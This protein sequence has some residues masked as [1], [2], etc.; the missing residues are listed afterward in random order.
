[1]MK[2]FKKEKKMNGKFFIIN[3]YGEL[4]NVTENEYIKWSREN[5]RNG[6]DNAVPVFQAPKQEEERRNIID[7]TIKELDSEKLTY[8]EYSEIRKDVKVNTMDDVKKEDRE[9]LDDDRQNFQMPQQQDDNLDEKDKKIKRIKKFLND[10]NLKETEMNRI[11]A[12]VKRLNSQEASYK[13]TEE[14]TN[15]R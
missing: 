11:D 12:E 7:N 1:M 3:E 2:G 15:G 9:R 5:N 6:K 14:K 10:L 13:D 8:E 4:V